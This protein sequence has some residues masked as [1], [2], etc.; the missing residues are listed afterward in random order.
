MTSKTATRA[1]LVLLALTVIVAAALSFASGAEI[2]YVDEADYFG[3]AE[4]L[5]AGQGYVTESLQPT[6]NRPPGYPFVMV[7]FVAVPR[8][9]L[10]LKLLNVLFL[11][12][13]IWLLR[14]MVARETPAV[15]WMA[16]GA[17]LAY[18]VWM[19]TAST[20]YPQTLCLLLLLALVCLL[21]RRPSA[22]PPFAAAGLLL[23]ALVL[24]APSFLLIAPLLG[25]YVV[26]FGPFS[27]R[28]NLVA[29]ALFAATTA[30]ALSPWTI[31]NYQ[32]FGAFVPVATNGGVNL[33]LGNSE[34]ARPNSG[35]DVDIDRYYQRLEG[36][37]EVE[38]SR[39]LQG[40]ALE[41][42]REHPREAAGLYARKVLN[43]FNF[44]AE[45]A[46]AQQNAGWK[47]LIMLVTYY[48]LL[49][50]VLV[51]L[52]LARRAPLSRAEGLLLWL[53]VANAFLAA[54]FFTR[55]RFRLPFDGLLMTLALIAVG[56]LWA[57]RR[58]RSTAGT[59]P[60]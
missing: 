52:C 46:T 4:R 27:L 56:R 12:A 25:L 40:F 10:L 9:V 19:Y 54:I 49:L 23:A 28:R 8:G 6:A 14:V 15:A 36:L 33:L 31:R 57:L 59:Q 39:A 3:L 32:A 37:D 44:R 17:A 43:Y 48:P 53:Y 18:P 45:L 1:F 7:P 55:I 38:S 29:A 30:A 16:G 35:V 13:S 34:N 41:W 22:L 11:A 42:V 51:R 24:V 5:V 20:L 26:F 50:L 58:P 60:A 21:T 2:R 47:D